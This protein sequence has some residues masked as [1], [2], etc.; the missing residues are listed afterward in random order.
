M[1]FAFSLLFLLSFLGGAN[2]EDFD[3]DKILHLGVTKAEFFRKL[4][5]E[6]PE[7]PAVNLTCKKPLLLRHCDAKSTLGLLFEVA[8]T[9]A[10]LDGL[11]AF[12][13]NEDPGFLYH[14]VLRVRQDTN[15]EDPR[16]TAEF[17]EYCRAVYAVANPSWDE[18]AADFAVNLAVETAGERAMRHPDSVGEFIHIQTPAVYVFLMEHRRVTGLAAYNPGL[19]KHE[20][21][22]VS[23]SCRVT[24]QYTTYDGTREIPN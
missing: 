2:S 22:F 7:L 24:A 13:A 4:A 14:V 12:H 18:S 19:K 8:D 17:L 5:V 6:F 9:P 3:P 11:E 10:H 16:L 20:G 1:R 21:S 23:A 15:Q